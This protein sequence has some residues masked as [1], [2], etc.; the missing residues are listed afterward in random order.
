MNEPKRSDKIARRESIGNAIYKCVRV[1]VDVLTRYIWKMLNA[2]KGT[3]C[4]GIINLR[5]RA[6]YNNTWATNTSTNR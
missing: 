6:K 3:M 2:H 5:L 4:F 1:C